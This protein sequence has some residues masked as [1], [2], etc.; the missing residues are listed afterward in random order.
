MS[1]HKCMQIRIQIHTPHTCQAN[2][3]ELKWRVVVAA[4]VAAL[5]RHQSAAP[6][7]QGPRCPPGCSSSQPLPAQ[8]L[9]HSAQWCPAGA[10]MSTRLQ[11][12]AAENQ[13]FSPQFRARQQQASVVLCEK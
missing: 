12:A 11:P 1:T 5:P 8:L 6:V 7:V 4:V 9:E 13:K 2:P 10:V 3:V